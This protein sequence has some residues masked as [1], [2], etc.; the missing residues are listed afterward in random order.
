MKVYN[1]NPCPKCKGEI[2]LYSSCNIVD[3]SNC[4]ARCKSCET[5]FVV[6]VELKARG[7][8]IYP[9]S[10]KKAYRI[11]NENSEQLKTR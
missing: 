9:A 4:F 8:K 6:P 1:T 3:G 5:E 7:A 2:E 10:I 11:W